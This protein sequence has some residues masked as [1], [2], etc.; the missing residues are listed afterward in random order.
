MKRNVKQSPTDNVTV[1]SGQTLALV[2]QSG[3]GKSTSVQ[4]LERFYDPDEGSVLIDGHETTKTNVTFLRSKIGIVSQEPVLFGGSVFDNIVYGD[5]TRKIS[6]A[7]VEEAAR[8]AN[9]Q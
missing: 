7:E 1:K 6:K 9:M 3:C 4:L 8:L 2:G 5:Q